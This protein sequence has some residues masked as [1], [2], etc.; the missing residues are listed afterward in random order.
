MQAW[1]HVGQLD[2]VLKVLDRRITSALVEITDKWRPVCW[3]QHR[4]VAADHDAALGI[5][6]M[7]LVFRGCARLN[8]R[9]TH[10]PWESHPFAI[11]IS[12]C[13]LQKLERPRKVAKLNADFLK[14]C[15]GIVLDELQ[16]FFVEDLEVW[17][18]AIDPRRCRR[19]RLQ[20]SSP[21]GRP[22]TL[23]ARSSAQCRTQ[24]V[25]IALITLQ[26]P[27]I[28]SSPAVCSRTQNIA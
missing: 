18:L 19:L 10:S 8:N 22:A 12:A 7:L 3:H 25:W 2:E 27:E 28:L 17:D 20:A 4:S 16:A 21:L 1:T 13:V 26:S 14:Q 23:T 9:A 6:G 15:L 5:T 11:D 24:S